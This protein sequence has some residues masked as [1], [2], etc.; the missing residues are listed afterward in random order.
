MGKDRT[1]KL[2]TLLKINDTELKTPKH[3]E[4]CLWVNNNI[5]KILYKC[6][7]E[8]YAK[9]IQYFFGTNDKT[10][11]WTSFQL[12]WEEPIKGRNGFV[13]GIPDFKY[14]ILHEEIEIY[15]DGKK[16]R[17]AYLFGGFIEV[18]PTV[19][20]I[21]ETMRQMK[22]YRSNYIGSN[23]IP[24]RG[25]SMSFKHGGQS[26]EGGNYDFFLVTNTKEFKNIFEKQGI[27]YI[28]PE[29]IK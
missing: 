25:V 3:D 17:I 9:L 19:K 13:I 1:G 27:F 28:I 4:L 10:K 18:K 11:A 16:H 2:D 7:E 24:F 22:L 23:G 8:K 29:E 20:S 6:L 12:D 21:G 14:S 5:E 26:T 15:D